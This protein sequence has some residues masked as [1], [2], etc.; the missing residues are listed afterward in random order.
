MTLEALLN[1]MVNRCVCVLLALSLVALPLSGIGQEASGC[2]SWYD[3][4]ALFQVHQQH[5]PCLPTHKAESSVVFDADQAVWSAL[6]AERPVYWEVPLT[7]PGGAHTTVIL[8]E[9]KAYRPDL[10]IGHMTTDGVR[11]ERYTPRLLSYRIANND[12]HGSLV[13]LDGQV[14]GAIRYL[15]LIHI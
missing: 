15:S 6:E 12:I 8:H 2:A 4:T 1:S 14:A 13:F 3:P 9:F 7:F 5:V 11:T 10:E